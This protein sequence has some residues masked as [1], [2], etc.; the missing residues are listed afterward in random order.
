VYG[1]IRRLEGGGSCRDKIQG[2]S[3][4]GFCDD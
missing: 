3:D 1:D 2:R 4:R